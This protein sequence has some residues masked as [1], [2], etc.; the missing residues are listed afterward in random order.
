M[1]ESA[2]AGQR[3]LHDNAG[4][5][6]IFP[7]DV[8]PYDAGDVEGILHE[9]HI[10]VA[11]S[12]QLAMQRVG[13]APGEQHDGQPITK[14][15]LDG[16]AG[17]GRSG[18]DMHEHRLPLAGRQRVAAGHMNGDDLVRAEDYLGMLAAFAVPARDLL[19]QRDMIGTEIG[20]D[21][22]NPEIDEAFEEIMRGTMTAHIRDSL[23]FLAGFDLV[24]VR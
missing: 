5:Q 23:C 24:F 8:R 21:I 2:G 16:H 19:D 18:I 4:R 7:F 13:R 12:G 9:M 22:F 1:H 17:I 10:S 15:V 20:E 14:Q 11:R 6:R 3:L